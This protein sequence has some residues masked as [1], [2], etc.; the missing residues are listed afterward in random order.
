MPKSTK[1]LLLPLPNVYGR[2]LL[3]C[4]YRTEA[5]LIYQHPESVVLF[6]PLPEWRVACDQV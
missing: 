6:N 4:S 2:A 1:A 5:I 3:L